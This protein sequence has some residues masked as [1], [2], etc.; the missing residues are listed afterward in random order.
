MTEPGD[1][2]IP[3]EIITNVIPIAPTPMTAVYSSMI[4]VLI[5]VTNRSKRKL[6]NST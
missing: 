2:S 4:A 5:Q 6:A 3:P 1:K